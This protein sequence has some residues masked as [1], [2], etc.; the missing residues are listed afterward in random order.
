M[1]VSYLVGLEELT[2]LAHFSGCSALPGFSALPAVEGE[3]C[4]ALLLGLDEKGM[5]QLSGD[6]VAVHPPLAFVIRTMAH[7]GL[8]ARAEN[9]ALAYCAPDLGVVVGRVPRGKERFRLTPTPDARELAERFWEASGAC[10]E[11]L[12]FA[13][14]EGS[15]GWCEAAM[16]RAELEALFARVYTEVVSE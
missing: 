7:A 2:V 11:S 3:R 6:R 12:A 9:G 1:S 16:A 14:C 4:R 15:G 10:F 5:V 8:T 13:Y